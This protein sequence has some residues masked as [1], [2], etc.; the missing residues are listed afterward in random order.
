LAVS[1]TGIAG[2]GGGTPTKPVGLV[3]IA[4][5]RRGQPTQVERTVFPGDR[6]AVREASVRRALELLRLR[7]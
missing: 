4:T 6:S 2:P 3:F 5:T 1:V 7:V